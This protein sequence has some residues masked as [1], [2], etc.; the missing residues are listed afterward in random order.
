MHLSFL[1]LRHA[2]RTLI[3]GRHKIHA[4]RS[5]LRL[6]LLQRPQRFAAHLR[7]SGVRAAFRLD[8]IISVAAACR[9]EEAPLRSRHRLLEQKNGTPMRALAQP[10]RTAA[11]LLGAPVRIEGV[12]ADRPTEAVQAAIRVYGLHVL[13]IGGREPFVRL[14][15]VEQRS[16][17]IQAND[18]GH[19][20]AVTGAQ[21]FARK[22]GHM[23]AQTVPDEL[24]AIE[25]ER[26]VGA[27]EI[28][29]FADR[30]TDGRR[31]A[32]HGRI[33]GALRRRTPIDDEHIEGFGE[34]IVGAAQSYVEIAVQVALPAVN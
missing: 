7:Q 15:D 13:R 27:H 30:S 16:R 10:V 14:L 5:L 4:T 6:L 9:L 31:S 22:A 34:R 24:R 8:A 21:I 32:T 17:R 20:A 26:T 29:E 19:T 18:G 25:T 12:H 28:D 3:E 11:H 23:R 1:L 33:V 2:K